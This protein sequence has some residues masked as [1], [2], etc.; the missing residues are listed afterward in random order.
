MPL[1]GFALPPYLGVF[2]IVVKP[3]MGFTLG[4]FWLVEAWRKGGIKQVSYVFGPAT[5]CLLASFA[6]LGLWP[7]RFGRTLGFWWNASLWPTSIP[8]GLAL[9]V[10]AFRRRRAEYALAA[11]PCL[12]PYV[13]F[14]S[15]SGALIALVSSEWETLAAVAGLWILVIL[16][17]VGG[18]A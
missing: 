3:Q 11:A 14:H 7:L 18:A 17:A 2:L 1:L 6:F 5:L 4:L 10:A 9:M 16:R 15:W 12:S 8:V 13:L